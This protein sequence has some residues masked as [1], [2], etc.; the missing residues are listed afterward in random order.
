[1]P[2]KNPSE[3]IAKVGQGFSHMLAACRAEMSMTQQ[4]PLSNRSPYMNSIEKVPKNM[5]PVL[6]NSNQ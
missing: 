2:Y 4:S 1:M 3:R 5:S 6:P